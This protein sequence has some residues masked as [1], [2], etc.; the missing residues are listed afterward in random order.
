MTFEVTGVATR[1]FSEPGGVVE[2]RTASFA[3]ARDV[4]LDF[5]DFSRLSG[6][7][8]FRDDRDHPD[9]ADVLQDVANEQEALGITM[10]V[11]SN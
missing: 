5:S 10:K 7:S 4:R 6:S 9:W 1:T 3:S 2:D 8:E 11:K